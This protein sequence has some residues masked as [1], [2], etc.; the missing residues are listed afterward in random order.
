MSLVRMVAVIEKPSG[1][2]I[3]VPSK[4][5]LA[6]VQFIPVS[7]L[8]PA[9]SQK[10]SGSWTVSIEDAVP[11]LHH[12]PQPKGEKGWHGATLHHQELHPPPACQC[13]APL[14]W[15]LLHG[16][17][18]SE[19][20]TARFPLGMK[21]LMCHRRL[22]RTNPNLP[23][24]DIIQYTQMKLSRHSQG[25]Q[26]SCWW[27][28]HKNIASIYLSQCAINYQNKNF[29]EHGDLK[30]QRLV[31]GGSR[32]PWTPCLWSH[33]AHSTLQSALNHLPRI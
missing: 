30:R 27:K 20:E 1:N 14:E 23:A 16:H 19:P 5:R 6:S 18:I 32:R 12:I 7:S 8:C 3:L 21:H 13:S 25:T 10:D 29:T 22:G 33:S 4:P 9:V 2:P 28:S 31:P 11:I 17:Y 24:G 15:S 26:Q